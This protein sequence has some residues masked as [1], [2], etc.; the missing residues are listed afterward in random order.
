MNS[1]VERF[2]SDFFD[3]TFELTKA[4]F[5][6][7]VAI[8]FIT[9]VAYF[10]LFVP[11]LFLGFGIGMDEILLISEASKDP[12]KLHEITGIF[13]AQEI[14]AKLVATA[15]I[16][17]TLSLLLM[18][19]SY[20]A[21]FSLNDQHIRTNS[22][23]LSLAL[24]EGLSPKIWSMMGASFLIILIYILLMIVAAGSFSASGLLGFVLLLAGL[25]FLFKFSVAIPS[26]VH[27][28]QGG[29]SS[30]LYSSNSISIGK[31]YKLF[32]I[33]IL[34]IIVLIVAML[35]V[36]GIIW[37]ISLIPI[38]GPIIG[39]LLN[40]A[41]QAGMSIFMIAG[42]SGLYFRYSEEDIIEN[43]AIPTNENDELL[44]V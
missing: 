36:T 27:G 24:K 28:N 2:K 9:L 25:G 44:D 21:Y 4:V 32:G 6:K 30:I 13:T 23:D 18:A 12:S 41:L 38:L 3:A 33:C 40:Y 35:I 37:V 15:V 22:S 11:A 42:L 26:I 5:W 1:I 19:W 14:S 31:A 10:I 43:D 8:Y 7:A 29:L 17:I 34:L 16:L 20:T 39:T